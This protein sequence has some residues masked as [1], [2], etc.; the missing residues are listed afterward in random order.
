MATMM[1]HTYKRARRFARRMLDSNPVPAFRGL[2]QGFL[3]KSG[4]CRSVRENLAVDAA[5]QPLPWFTYPAIAFLSP[6]VRPAMRVF[7][8]GAGAST[9]WWAKRVREV[10]ACEHYASW[11]EKL[12]AEAPGNV[13]LRHVELE[14][15]GDY[16]RT[17]ARCGER[18]DVIVIDGRDRVNCALHS[19][20]ALSD[21]GVIIWDNADRAKYQRGYDFLT[22]RGFRRIDFTGLGPIMCEP[23]TTAVFYRDGNCL[24]I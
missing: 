1:Y 12:R 22:E 18:F 7:E 24:G 19:V 17:A 5:G 14:S 23:W 4:W 6:R 8:F 2:Y 15:D 10:V 20:E 21:A 9:L 16:C 11:V 13:T 3:L